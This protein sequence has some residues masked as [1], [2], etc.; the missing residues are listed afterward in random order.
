[1]SHSTLFDRKSGFRQRRMQSHPLADR[2]RGSRRGWRIPGQDISNVLTNQLNCNWKRE[3]KNVNKRLE[4]EPHL[5]QNLFQGTRLTR[6]VQNKNQRNNSTKNFVFKEC[7]YFMFFVVQN[8]D[9]ILQ[10]IWYSMRKYKSWK[11]FVVENVWAII[12][13]WNYTI[14]YGKVNKDGLCMLSA[15]SRCSKMQGKYRSFGG[16]QQKLTNIFRLG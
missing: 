12:L 11:K 8:S 7:I 3:Q 14:D 2:G 10:I 16:P 5:F 1:M 6:D 9:V 15:F 13:S 4:R